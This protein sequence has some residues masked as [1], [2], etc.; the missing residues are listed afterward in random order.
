MKRSTIISLSFFIFFFLLNVSCERSPQNLVTETKCQSIINPIGIDVNQPSFSWIVESTERGKKQIA[1]QILLADNK[2]DINRNSGNYWDSGKII[3]EKNHSVMYRGKAL[4]SNQ[5]YYWKVRIW[6]EQDVPTEYSKTTFFTTSIL[7]SDEW[8]GKWIGRGIA[9]APLNEEGFYQEK[10]EVDADG[11]SIKYNGTSLLLRKEIQLAKT[12]SKALVN[13]SGLGFYEFS[14]NGKRVGDRVLNPAKTNYTQLVLFDT[15]EVSELLDK[16]ENVL[17]IMVGN[18]WFDPIPKWWSWRM[19]WFGE[20]QAML[21]MHITYKDGS[22]EVITT[23]NTWKIADGPIRH[24]CIYDGETYDATKEIAD[25]GK[26]GFDDSKWESAKNVE[27]PKGKFTAQIMPA[28]KRVETI[29]PLSVTYPNDSISVVN[30]G[31]NFSGWVRIKVRTERGQKTIIRFAENSKDGMIDTKS[32][33]K[34]VTT[35]TY[36]AKGEKEEIFEPRFTYHGFQYVEVSGLPYQLEAEDIEAVVVHS[37]VEQ[38]G[39]F[40]C[41]NEQINNI[42]KAVLWSYRSNLMGYPTDCPQREERL[43]WIGDAH[44][45]AEAG[46]YNFEVNQFYNKWLDDIRVNQD[47]NNGYIPYIAPRPISNGDPAFSWSSG[48][49]LI[50]WYHYLYYGDKKILEENY[51]AMKKYVDYLSTLADKYI[52]PNDKYGDWVSPLDGWKRGTPASISTGYYYYNSSIVAKAAKILGNNEDSKTYGTLSE[53]IKTAFYQH[54][55]N[56]ETKNYE[57]GSQFSNSFA[58]FLG[59]VPESEKEAVLNNLVNDI[60]NTHDT[61]LT[62]G[63]LG[64]KYLMELLSRE[65]RSDVAWALATQTTFPS[66]I[67]MLKDRTTLSEKWDKSGSSN[68]VMLGSIDSWFYQTLA[69]IQV[70]EDAPGFSEFVIKPFMP[71]DLSWVKA[72]VKT[73]KGTVKSEWSIK[74]GNYHLNIQVPFGSEAIVYI[75]G[76]NPDNISESGHPVEQAENVE[77]LWKEDNYTVFKVG[78]GEYSFGS[79]SAYKNIK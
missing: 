52:L 25:W 28:I 54:F 38:T 16:G 75:I 49:H 76:D 48:Y 5:T 36:I 67:D 35:D 43:G 44:V 71:E 24:H 73:V 56:A 1:Y 42:H 22:T 51:E 58:L 61:H 53:N 6:D 66:W 3:S 23:D 60:V 77:F 46:I 27:A 21:N 2:D 50:A 62:T 40:E 45:V 15:Y 9:K 17:G 26:P 65:G 68:H 39:S 18:G 20:K 47:K 57:E 37:A 8:K 12:V 59:L 72:S 31:Q 29:K 13:V 10:I 4:Q 14:I 74:N 41:S 32:N 63:I 33:D 70:Q 69:G 55:Y 64:T 78:S 79:S 30:F 11:D 7:D 34:A 19:Q